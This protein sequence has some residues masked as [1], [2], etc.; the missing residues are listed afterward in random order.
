L[1]LLDLLH[2]LAA[3]LLAQ[4]APPLHNL[5]RP[6]VIAHLAGLWS[7]GRIGQQR[8]DQR[9]RTFFPYTLSNDACLSG[10]ATSIRRFGFDPGLF[11]DLLG[12]SAKVLVSLGHGVCVRAKRA[13]GRFQEEH[14]FSGFL[15]QRH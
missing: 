1:L 8:G 10:K 6:L 7:G 13:V 3:D 12:D 2:H 9:S 5:L 4:R 15:S 11:G 14:R